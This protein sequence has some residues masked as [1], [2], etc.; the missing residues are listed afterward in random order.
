[1]PVSIYIP[2]R[3]RLDPAALQKREAHIQ[4][5]LADGVGRALKNSVKSVAAHRG[6]FVEVA[7]ASPEFT[8]FGEAL[9]E[10]LPASREQFELLWSQVLVDTVAANGAGRSGK[11]DSS[12]P[13]PLPERIF[14]RFDPLRWD[15]RR[16]LYRI[17][18]YE[19]E[20]EEEAPVEGGTGNATEQSEEDAKRFMAEQYGVFFPEIESEEQLLAALS[21]KVNEVFGGRPG[22]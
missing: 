11:D 9:A 7:V 21:R 2:I 19:G 15:R 4:E 22:S 1:M 16:R 8:W 12:T 3:M 13:E 6:R 14:E 5:A 10:V 18:S 20:A 17:P